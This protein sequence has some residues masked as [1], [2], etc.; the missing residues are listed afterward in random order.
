MLSIFLRCNII[1]AYIHQS[2]HFL[3]TQIV[4]ALGSVYQRWKF[5]VSILICTNTILFVFLQILHRHLIHTVPWI[6][7]NLKVSVSL[8]VTCSRLF[9]FTKRNV[10]WRRCVANFK[11]HIAHSFAY[12]LGERCVCFTSVI[13]VAIDG[14]RAPSPLDLT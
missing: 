9:V 12:S 3:I 10:L 13:K 11:T 1:S 2:L 5:H 6:V 8:N 4:C 7:L 14:T